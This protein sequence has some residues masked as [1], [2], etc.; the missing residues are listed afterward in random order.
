MGNI[1]IVAFDSISSLFGCRW[2]SLDLISG[3][4][5]LEFVEWKIMVT[6]LGDHYQPGICGGFLDRYHLPGRT[7]DNPISLAHQSVILADRVVRNFSN[8]EPETMPGLFQ[9]KSC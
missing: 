5:I 7:G 1:G 6:K 9:Q 3:I 4:F 2:F 8:P